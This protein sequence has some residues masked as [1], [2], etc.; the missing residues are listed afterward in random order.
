MK[1][2]LIAAR[3]ENDLIGNGLD[4]PWKAKGEQLLFKALTFNAWLIVGRKTFESMGKLPNRKFAVI[5]A[6]GF[7]S[8]DPDVS[9]FSSVDSALEALS[10]LTDHAFIA[11]GGQIYRELIDKADVLH[12]ARI[13]QEVEGDISFPEIP[14]KFSRVFVQ[15]F[16]SN[17]NYSYEIWMPLGDED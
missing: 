15:K 9:V 5:S 11:G 2:S 10:D 8:N 17:I 1:L 13:H 3:S 16:Q 4:I 6:N 14:S 12:L 7:Q